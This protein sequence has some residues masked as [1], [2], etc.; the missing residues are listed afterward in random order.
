MVCVPFPQGLTLVSHKKDRTAWPQREAS[1]CTG[2]AL[3]Q[4]QS[5]IPVR[6]RDWQTSIAITAET[7]LFKLF[8]TLNSRMEKPTHLKNKI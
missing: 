6:Q 7:K 3:A 4:L 2:P 1:S 5:D 8:R